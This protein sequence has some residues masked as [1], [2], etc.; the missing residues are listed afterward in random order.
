MHQKNV[1]NVK[2]FQAISINVLFPVMLVFLYFDEAYFVMLIYIVFATWY[3]LS[4]I[5]I[6]KKLFNAGS[7]GKGYVIKTFVLLIVNSIFTML[8][9]VGD[10]EIWMYLCV[11]GLVYSAWFGYFESKTYYLDNKEVI[12]NYF[13]KES[14]SI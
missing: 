9:R 13:R 14:E 8:T 1:D 10:T 6:Y 2:K 3:A 4:E 12:D 5:A 11:G 7:S